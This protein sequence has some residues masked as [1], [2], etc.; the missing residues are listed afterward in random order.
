M[1]LYCPS[2]TSLVLSDILD[3]CNDGTVITCGE[4]L[5][6]FDITGSFNMPFRVRSLMKKQ[7]LW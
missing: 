3:N 7:I 6:A 2:L 4:W 5:A 1:L